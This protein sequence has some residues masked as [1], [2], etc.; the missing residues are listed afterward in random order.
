ME[1]I[2]QFRTKGLSYDILTDTAES[3]V[4]DLFSRY[5]IGI[6][7][8]KALTDFF[9]ASLEAGR[10][11]LY[12]CVSAL[13]SAKKAAAE[14]MAAYPGRRIICVD[15][16]SVSEDDGLKVVKMSRLRAAGATLDEIASYYEHHRQA[17]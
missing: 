6:T 5:N 16:P 7:D 2:V 4:S 15:L 13:E 1:K 8:T 10:D 17:V 14:L 11:I 12:I 9:R 3:P